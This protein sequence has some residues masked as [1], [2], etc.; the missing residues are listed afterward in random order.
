MYHVGG[1]VY[2]MIFK[3]SRM[4]L[5]LDFSFI[6]LPGVLAISLKSEM[7]RVNQQVQFH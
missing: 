1:E 5:M 3:L 7:S 6:L 2:K 4:I